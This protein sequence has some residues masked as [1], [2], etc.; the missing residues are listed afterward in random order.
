MC[1]AV[2]PEL[3]AHEYA[4]LIACRF[5]VFFLSH[6]RVSEMVEGSPLGRTVSRKLTVIGH[7]EFRRLLME[8]AAVHGCRVAFVRGMRAVGY[9]CT[10]ATTVAVAVDRRGVDD[11][12]VL[13]LR[14][15]EPRRRSSLRVLLPT[16]AS[17]RIETHRRPKTS[18][19]TVSAYCGSSIPTCTTSAFT[20]RVKPVVL[21]GVVSQP[22]GED[23]KCKCTHLLA[24]T[25]VSLPLCVA[26]ANPLIQ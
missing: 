13:Q 3:P 4:L 25:V 19:D 17:K 22:G 10:L 9:V 2:L 15:R 21:M 11:E 12:D 14:V 23:S 7:G 5:K 1:R 16:V 18:W 26:C 24:R 8:K 6:F 20:G